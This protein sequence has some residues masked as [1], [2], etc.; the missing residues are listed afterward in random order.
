MDAEAS[1]KPEIDLY[2]I[3]GV[4]RSASKDEIR[5]AYRKYALANHPDK[6]PEAEREAAEIR[7]KAAQQAYEILYDDS[8][9]QL[10]DTQGMAAFEGPQAGGEGPDISDLFAEMMFGAAG[11]ARGRRSGKSP[12]EEQKYEVSLEDL[13]KGKTVKFSSTKQVICSQCKGSGGKERAKAKECSV[14]GGQG[15]KTVLRQ[16]GPMLTQTMVPCSNCKGEGHIYDQKDRCKKC[17]GNKTIEEQKQLEIYIPRGAKEGDTIRLEGEADQTPGQ[18]PGDIVFHLIETEHD[19]F[20]RAGADLQAPLDITLG[21]ALC[22]FSRTV[23]KHLDGR[24]IS[25]THPQR[26]GQFLRP[27]QVL[28]I[29]GEGMP[30]KKSDAKGDLYLTVEIEFPPDGTLDTAAIDSLRN[31]LPP[32]E[33][34]EI[35]TEEVDEVAYDEDGN[36]DDFGQGDPRGGS[37]WVDDDEEAADGAQQCRQQ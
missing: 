29:P 8:K 35:E 13:Y 23:I 26:P 6:V 28:K 11:G 24:G 27:L 31:I 1:E 14:C 34:P 25:L 20:R 19:I 5:K 2:E 7:F 4:T 3:L 36:I 15:S 33:F 10:Y 16:V 22:G 9:R 18:E 17:K 12:D 21:E 32:P 30:H 37:G